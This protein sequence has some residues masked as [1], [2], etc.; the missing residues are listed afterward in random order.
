[1]LVYI[2]PLTADCTG[3]FYSTQEWAGARLDRLIGHPVAESIRVVSSTGYDRRF[4]LERASTLLL[5]TRA[6]GQPLDPGHG[7]PARLIVPDGRGFW[8]VKWVTAV[9]ADDVPHWWQPPFPI[10]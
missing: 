5:A 4:P 9:E 7:F 8:W 2:G 6:G 10:Q 1:M 3:G